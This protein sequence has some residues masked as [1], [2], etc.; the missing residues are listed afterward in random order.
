ML[1][2]KNSISIEKPLQEVFEFVS[3][4]VNNT[5]W[6][7][8]LTR[9]EK[10]NNQEGRGAEYLQFRKTDQQKFSIH[11]Y[12][13]NELVVLQTLPGERPSVNRRMVFV[14]DE[15]QCTIHDQMVFRV[16]L[17]RLFSRLLLGGPRKA[18]RQNLE[19]LKTLLET[20]QVILQ[21]GQHSTYTS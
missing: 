14:G 6:N 10:I 20:G 12:K 1:S 15:K 11:E 5:K 9:V 17:P 19:K 16:P 7:Y 2:F 4:P 13:S 3:D 18:V 21:D 8:F